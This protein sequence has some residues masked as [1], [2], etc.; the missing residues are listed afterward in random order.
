MDKGFTQVNNLLIKS[1]KT[2][3]DKEFRLFCILRSYKFD[4]KYSF[5][6]RLKIAKEMGC[7]VSTV[8]TVKNSLQ[9]KGLIKKV[10]RGQ[11]KTNLYYF[12][13]DFFVEADNQNVSFQDNQDIGRKEEKNNNKSHNNYLPTSN[14]GLKTEKETRAATITKA[15]ADVSSDVFGSFSGLVSQ[16][17]RKNPGKS[18]PKGSKFALVVF[19]SQLKK[20]K[21]K[22]DI[23]LNA[24]SDDQLNSEE[25]EVSR[26]TEA[27][28]KSIL[29][30]IEKYQ[31]TLGIEHPFYKQ[32]QLVDCFKNILNDIWNIEGS[33]MPVEETLIK[34]IDRWFATTRLEAN[35]LK[36]SHFVGAGSLI[37]NNSIAAIYAE[38]HPPQHEYEN[39]IVYS[40][41]V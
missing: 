31:L 19:S 1:G 8:D 40:D 9:K 27:A 12:N 3:T 33:D 4:N 39:K 16:T 29:Y 5:P 36:L 37:L 2:L 41:V 14:S 15:S 30:Y 20:I 35:N 32:K 24:L 28:R 17:T 21:Q 26:N 18:K 22:I 7:C 13:E 11:G 23:Q 10:R 38:S 25:Y 34:A 6:G